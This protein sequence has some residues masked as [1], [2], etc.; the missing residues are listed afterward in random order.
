MAAINSQAIVVQPSRPKLTLVAR[1]TLPNWSAETRKAIFKHCKDAHSSITQEID[2]ISERLGPGRFL[3]DRTIDYLLNLF[4]P[5]RL[6][7]EPE[8]QSNV[9]TALNYTKLVECIQYPNTVHGT[10][11]N[12]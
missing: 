3:H 10:K 7:G 4:C 2:Q 8:R 6:A 1:P 11:T 12:R 5:P 9:G